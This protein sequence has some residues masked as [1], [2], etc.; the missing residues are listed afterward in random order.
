MFKKFDREA[1]ADESI[2][3]VSFSPAR[4]ELLAQF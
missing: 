4:P 2:G 1:A 3:G